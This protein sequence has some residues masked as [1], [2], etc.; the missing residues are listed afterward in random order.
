M[1]IDKSTAPALEPHGGIPTR[2]GGLE[3]WKLFGE[4]ITIIFLFIL[5]GLGD[6]TQSAGLYGKL[7]VT[8]TN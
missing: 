8:P 3:Q 6:F 2:S 4:C 7:F 5:A 1:Q